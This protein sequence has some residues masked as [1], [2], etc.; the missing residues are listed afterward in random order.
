[1]FG[2]NHVLLIALL[3]SG[4]LSLAQPPA[5][6]DVEPTGFEIQ[7]EVKP[8]QNSWIYL[9][10]YFG[11]SIRLVDS[12]FINE[13]SETV[14][15]GATLLEGG[16]YIIYL[17]DQTGSIDL[18]LDSLQQFSVFID[19]TDPGNLYLQ[20]KGSQENSRLNE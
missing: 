13:K 6:P 5:R 8:F 4:L 16:I 7:V 11:E 14:F 15:R 12:A 20:F 10:H 3:G 9:A 18:L 19:L 2:K 17:P 1:M